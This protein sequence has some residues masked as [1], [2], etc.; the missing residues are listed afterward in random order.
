MPAYYAATAASFLRAPTNEIVGALSMASVHET[1]PEQNRAWRD[2][3]ETLKSALAEIQSQQAISSEWGVLFEYP[4]L[5]LGRRLDAVVLAG[6]AVCVLEF[7]GASQGNAAASRRQAEDYA[8]DLRYFHAPTAALRVFPAVCAPAVGELTSLDF[9]SAEGV[10][11]ALV[12]PPTQLG[13]FLLRAFHCAADAQQ[14]SLHAWNAGAYRPV[15]TIIQAASMIYVNNSVEEIRTAL[16]HRENLTAT[17]DRLAEIRRWAIQ[18][19]KH[20][21]CFVTG[22]PGS[23]KTLVGLDLV[24]D[25]KFSSEKSGDAAFLSGNSPLVAVLREAL[26]KE[27]ARTK[28]TSLKRERDS[29]RARIQHLMGYLNQ[30]LNHDL[31]GAPHEHVIVF[32]EAQRAWDEAYGKQKFD[33]TASEPMLFLEIMARHADW[34]MIVALV[35]GGQEINR[36]EH[37]LIEWGRA[38]SKYNSAHSR[39]WVVF[40][41][42]ETI[43]GRALYGGTPL[44]DAETRQ[45]T[46]AK[47]ADDLHL[48]VAIRNYRSEVAID[49]IAAVLDGRQLDARRLAAEAGVSKFPLF[50]TRSLDD[51]R[52]WLRET[53]LGDRRYGLL[54]TSGARRLRGY[55]LGS[56]LKV[57]EIQEIV[58]WF[59]ADHHDLRSSQAL[60]VTATEFDCQGLEIDRACVCWDHNM[61]WNATKST[62]LIRKFQGT[63]WKTVQDESARRY[64]ANSYRVLLSRAR[65]AMVIWVPPG[66]FADSTRPPGEM[67]ATY[68]FLLSCG[69]RELKE[70]KR[71]AEAM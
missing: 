67:D 39:P 41:N 42:S 45:R 33:R 27:A 20:V 25:E 35:G 22:V 31:A 9:V 15:P 18:E 60:E 53:S 58:H 7:K 11:R 24:H 63:Q 5:R 55:G 13:R 49:W 32:D 65:E 64:V 1:T 17:I 66:H 68:R 47:A 14:I 54:A 36:G 34:A 37:G 29:V 38:L 59:L 23:G 52:A 30:Y 56:T 6:A 12:L 3:I 61:V 70:W 26:A 57:S 51:A 19:K 50:I 2:S 10:A 16:S 21:V 46:E 4:L 28:G 8:A 62:W 40:A 44:W 43:E 69:V 71:A 48:S